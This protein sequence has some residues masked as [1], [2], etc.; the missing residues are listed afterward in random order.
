[1]ISTE[2]LRGHIGLWLTLVLDI[3]SDG[4]TVGDLLALR[5]WIEYGCEGEPPL[6]D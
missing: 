1:M 5:D 2:E 4:P 3:S 6:P